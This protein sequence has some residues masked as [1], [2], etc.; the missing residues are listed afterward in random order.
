MRALALAVA[1]VVAPVAAHAAPVDSTHAAHQTRAVMTAGELKTT[2]NTLLQE[3]VYL[4]TGATGAALGGRQAEFQAA[5]AALDGN[6]QDIAKAIGAVYG[7]DA[8]TAFLGLWR[9]HI[10]FVVDYTTGLATK[11]VAKQ[12]QAVTA[13][14]GYTQEFA[15]FLS[16][17][18]PNLPKDAV[19]ELVKTHILTL[20]DVIDAQ[21]TMDPQKAWA[22]L[23]MAGMHMSMIANPLADAIVKQFPSRFA[24]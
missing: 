19:A 17:A 24:N 5:A 1:L 20:K 13:L 10:G 16:G 8:G 12:R 23:R 22:A 7:A 14:L 21:A 4:A 3:H 6:S 9:R 15:A 2:L 11:D 18:N